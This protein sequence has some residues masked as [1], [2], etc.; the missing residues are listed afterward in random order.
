MPSFLDFVEGT[1]VND[2]KTDYIESFSIIPKK[3][4]LGFN[5]QVV[6]KDK[7]YDFGKVGDLKSV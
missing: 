3:A 1:P 7:V 6:G 2:Y 4:I 5:V